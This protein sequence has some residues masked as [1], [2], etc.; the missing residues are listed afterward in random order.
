MGKILTGLLILIVI[1][2]VCYLIFIALTNPSLSRN[3]SPDQEVMPSIKLLDNNKIKINNI[4]NIHYRTTRDYDL[5][6]YDRTINL[7]DV[8]SAWLAISPFGGFGVA[9]TFVSFGLKDGTYLAISVEVRRKKGTSFDPVKAFLR[10]FEIMYVIADESD[11][12]KVRT[13]TIKATVRLFPIHTDKAR[14]QSVF[15]DM[16]KRADKLGKEPEFYNTIWNNCT[17][18]IVKHAKRFSEKPIP[19]WDYRYLVPEDIDKIAYRLNMIDTDLPYKEAR[20]HFD[21]TKIA[22]DSDDTEDFSKAIRANM[23][24]RPVEESK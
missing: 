22:Q 8:E 16:I 2:V 11:V 23:I 4:R 10:Q 1:L 20:E 18:N 6:F 19:L 7:E 9:H 3:W 15:L 12:I 13:N 24:R 14:I 5:Q 17:T 21:I